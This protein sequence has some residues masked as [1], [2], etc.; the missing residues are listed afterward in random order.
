MEYSVDV[1]ANCPL[2]SGDANLLQ[3]LDGSTTCRN[4]SVDCVMPVEPLV[5]RKWLIVPDPSEMQTR[6]IVARQT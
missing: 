6:M 5:I 3:T 2:S 1:E 4:N